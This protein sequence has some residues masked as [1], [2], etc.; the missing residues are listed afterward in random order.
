MGFFIM[1][2]SFIVGI[3][4]I[5]LG[6]IRKKDNKNLS[7]PIIFIGLILVIFAIWLGLPK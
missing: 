2:L 4:F 1:L 3:F 6:F 5:A 7:I